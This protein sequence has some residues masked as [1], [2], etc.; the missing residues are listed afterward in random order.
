MCDIALLVDSSYSSKDYVTL[1]VKAINRL[2]FEC[3]KCI[4]GDTQP[5]VTIATFDNVI[6]FYNIGVNIDTFSKIP[7][8]YKVHTGCTSLYDNFSIFISDICRIHEDRKTIIIVITDGVDTSSERMTI[9]TVKKYVEEVSKKYPYLFVYLGTDGKQCN[10]GREMG[11]NY[12]ILYSQSE[13]SIEL[14]FIQAFALIKNNKNV[15]EDVSDDFIA[16]MER[17]KI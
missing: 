8:D 2:L 12:S 16:R 13:R 6:T 11:C 3:W 14:A 10:I 1:Y 17:L 15:Q 5:L 9:G 7:F 4:G